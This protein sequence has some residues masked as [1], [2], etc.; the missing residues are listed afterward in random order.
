MKL[1]ICSSNADWIERVER[2]D[3][4]RHQL[5][6]VRKVD[7]GGIGGLQEGDI[8]LTLNDKL[9]SRVTDLDIMYNNSELE[10][11]IVR[12]R[13][14]MRITVATVPTADLETDRV[15]AFCGAVL[16][17]PHH[18]VRQQ[19]SKVH[20]DVYVSGR[21]SLFLFLFFSL[22]TKEAKERN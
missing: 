9:I 15:V 17:R 5:F 20:S 12:K 21:V 11:V 18:A 6:M 13:E 2:E 3:P 8:I 19:I 14:E 7:S 22:Y 16:H 10:A 1:N 4:E